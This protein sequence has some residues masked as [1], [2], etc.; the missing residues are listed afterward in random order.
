VGCQR[1]VTLPSC[2]AQMAVLLSNQLVSA[3]YLAIVLN[4]E[5]GE[6]AEGGDEDEEERSIPEFKKGEIIPL[7]GSKIESISSKIAVASGEPVR[8]NLLI[9][10][11]KTTPPSMLTES[12][13]IGLMEKVSLCCDGRAWFAEIVLLNACLRFTLV[14]S[15]RS[16]E[17]GQT[18]VFLPTLR[19]FKSET[20]A[21]F[22]Q[23]VVACIPR[24]W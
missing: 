17:L 1:N 10:E 16:M 9:R 13:L 3:G 8:A 5:Y 6:D 15:L 12:E 20:I 19:I 23:P 11:K 14:S 7:A 21:R 18:R 4:R 24:S 22:N 2:W